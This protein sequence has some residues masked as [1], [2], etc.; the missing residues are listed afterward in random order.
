MPSKCKV[1]QCDVTT[2]C[3]PRHSHLSA[4]VTA[5]ISF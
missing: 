3:T 5:C 2:S 4:N 1:V